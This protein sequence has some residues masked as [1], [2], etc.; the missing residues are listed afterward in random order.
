MGAK[1]RQA[2]SDH[3]LL[4]ESVLGGVFWEGVIPDSFLSVCGGHI[5]RPRNFNAVNGLEWPRIK[6][7]L[8][9]EY[10]GKGHWVCGTARTSHRK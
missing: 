7:L 2:L 4:G 8:V 9:R 3:G 10:V 6:H 5:F 1:R